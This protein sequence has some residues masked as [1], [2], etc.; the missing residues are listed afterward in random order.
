MRGK[1]QEREI[2]NLYVLTITAPLPLHHLGSMY[3]SLERRREGR[4]G[5]GMG[6]YI[7]VFL[8]VLQPDSILIGNKLN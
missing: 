3:R 4:E 1:E 8:C 7:F 6:R 5:K 2:L